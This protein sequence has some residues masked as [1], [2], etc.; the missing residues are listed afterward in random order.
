M[1]VG[2]P[3]SVTR[4]AVLFSQAQDG[5]GFTPNDITESALRMPEHDPLS[6]TPARSVGL[7]KEM[8]S[9]TVESFSLMSL[10][11]GVRVKPVQMR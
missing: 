9:D 7:S 11:E 2:D 8:R 1:M 4:S 5:G 3:P 6:G 10:I